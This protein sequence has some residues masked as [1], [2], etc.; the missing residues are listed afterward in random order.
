MSPDQIEVGKTYKLSEED[1]FEF[2]VLE[3]KC[4]DAEE[5]LVRYKRE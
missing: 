4:G 3:I 5:Y 2:T 1:P